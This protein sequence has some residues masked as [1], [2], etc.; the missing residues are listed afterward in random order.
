MNC[1]THEYVLLGIYATDFL[2]KM[3]DKLRQGSGGTYIINVQ[4]CLEKLAIQKTKLLLQLNVDID[5]LNVETGH[6]CDN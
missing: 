1:T 3:F 2:E 5:S 6:S 4:Q